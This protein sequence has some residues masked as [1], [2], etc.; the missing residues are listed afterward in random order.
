MHTNLWKQKSNQCLPKARAG[1]RD[2]LQRISRTLSEMMKMV[3][4][5]IGG[6]LM[7][8]SPVK[9]QQLYTSNKCSF[10]YV[11]SISDLT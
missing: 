6:S 2:R 5:L 10:L 7:D 4:I 11:N 8:V 3:Y 9:T 1:G